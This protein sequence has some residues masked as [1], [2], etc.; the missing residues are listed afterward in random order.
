[1]SWKVTWLTVFIFADGI[2]M[3]TCVLAMC[4]CTAK[5][6]TVCPRSSNLFYIANYIEIDWVTTSRTYNIKSCGIRINTHN[7]PISSRGFVVCW[8]GW[9]TRG[10]LELN[11]K[12]VSLHKD[13]LY[14][15]M[16]KW[17]KNLKIRFKVKAV[18][19]ELY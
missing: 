9:S 13:K 5:L 15:R 14:N 6:T 10:F 8:F 19:K 7:T 17:L 3:T 11:I 1:M 2:L 18:I 4:S 12:T 16:S